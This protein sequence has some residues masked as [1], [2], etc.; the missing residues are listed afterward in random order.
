MR[1]PARRGRPCAHCA[2]PEKRRY[3]HCPVQ[4][5]YGRRRDRGTRS[6][7]PW[8]LVRRCRL[9]L[10]VPGFVVAQPGRP[11]KCLRI[12]E[13]LQAL[14]VASGFKLIDDKIS[15]GNKRRRQ[16]GRVIDC[17]N[18][19]AAPCV[20]ERHA[21]CVREYIDAKRRVA[22]REKRIGFGQFVR[23]YAGNRRTKFR[24]RSPDDLAVRAIRSN[25]DVEVFGLRMDR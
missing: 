21:R 9:R 13:V 11:P 12:R 1:Y 10:V 5:G 7:P 23:S 14:R 8:A 25:E 16:P 15:G 24:E 4:R 20:F 17:V 6:A 22:P 19:A 18:R 2:V 3:N